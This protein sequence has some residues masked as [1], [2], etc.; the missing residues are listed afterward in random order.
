MKENRLAVSM[1]DYWGKHQ[2]DERDFY[3][4][5]YLVVWMAILMARLMGLHL[6]SV[7]VANW[8]ILSGVVV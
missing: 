4:A 3:S 1:V 2:D 5:Y 7:M 8:A 6:D